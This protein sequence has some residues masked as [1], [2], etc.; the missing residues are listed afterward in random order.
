MSANMRDFPTGTILKDDGSGL[1]P[2]EFAVKN[3]SIDL[4]KLPASVREKF[5]NALKEVMNTSSTIDKLKNIKPNIAQQRTLS[6]L[7]PEERQRVLD[8]LSTMDISQ[9]A[10][11]TT[12]T[13]EESTQNNA[14][15]S[16]PVTTI[17]DV[18]DPA[19]PALTE[20][21]LCPNCAWN[22][23]HTTEELD[24]FDKANWLRSILGGTV[25]V[26]Q[27]KLFN[28]E[29]TVTFRTRLTNEIN[30]I[31]EQ[32]KKEL[33]DGRIPTSPPNVSL[34][35]YH[36]RLRRLTLTCSLVHAANMSRELPHVLSK[37]AQKLYNYSDSSKDTYVAQ[38]Y[39]AIFASWHESLY[40]IV[41]KQFLVFESLCFRLT[42]AA[43][44]PNFWEN[45]KSSG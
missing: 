27:Y 32:L 31:Q 14:A 3:G 30:Q 25:F 28:G 43:A 39:N 29:V 12:K 9:I 37:D 33:A 44:S 5:A 18:S 13:T 38:A 16:K 23:D 36:D 6:D 22:T 34:M 10:D 7:P 20:P 1:T 11:T 19:Q 45:L 42:E 40:H 8:A 24:E 4:E 21:K 15:E 35:S 2:I 41:F 26:K 17:K